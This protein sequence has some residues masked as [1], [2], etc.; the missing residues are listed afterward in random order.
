MRNDGRGPDQDYWPALIEV[1]ASSYMYIYYKR[2]LSDL[3][4]GGG[5]E[6][7]RATPPAASGLSAQ[8]TQQSGAE[9]PSKS[10]FPLYNTPAASKLIIFSHSTVYTRL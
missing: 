7:R 10:L 6:R 9:R 3:L 4:P 1:E 2:R 5:E 8:T